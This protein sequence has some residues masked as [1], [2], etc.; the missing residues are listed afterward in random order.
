MVGT[1]MVTKGLDF[2]RVRLVGILNADQLLSYPDF[3]SEERTF[4]L[5]AQVGGRA[6]RR[7]KRGK[8]IIQTLNPEHPVF[9]FIISH[10]Y[11]EF[12]HY[13]LHQRNQFSYPP[14]SRLIQLT[15]SHRDNETVKA[16]ANHTA[17]QLKLLFG[18]RVLGPESP[19]IARLK[20]LYLQQ[21]LIKFEKDYS[22]LA[23]AK[24]RLISTLSQL[25]L[26]GSYKNVKVKIDVDPY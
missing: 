2:E 12:Y 26:H 8:V 15:F 9:Q 23:Q 13:L 5:I 4:Q 14:Y 20:N 25:Q 19:V 16:A 7:E 21:I 24:S 17:R 3:R 11:D 6:G 10:K 18:D 22:S 1:Q